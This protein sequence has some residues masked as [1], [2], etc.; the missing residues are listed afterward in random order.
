MTDPLAGSRWSCSRPAS[1]SVATASRCGTWIRYVPS[2]A[3]STANASPPPSVATIA[4][5]R[6]DQCAPGCV[7]ELTLN[8]PPPTGRTVHCSLRSLSCEPTMKKTGGKTGT[9]NGANSSFPT[10]GFS[11]TIR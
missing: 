3:G 5:P 11:L 1:F 9:V 10:A 4:S 6:T 7:V 8:A 2:P